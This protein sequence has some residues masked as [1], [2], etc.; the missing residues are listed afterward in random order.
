MSWDEIEVMEEK[1]RKWAVNRYT[2]TYKIYFRADDG[3]DKR[4]ALQTEIDHVLGHE[5]QFTYLKHSII[6]RVHD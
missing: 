5:D 1:E 4:A 3:E 6:A 2:R